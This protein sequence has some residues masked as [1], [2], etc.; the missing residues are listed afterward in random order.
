VA[1]RLSYVSAFYKNGQMLAEQYRIWSAYPDELKAQMEIVLVEDGDS[2]VTEHAEDVPRPDG[3]PDL[4]IYRL[5]PVQ[6][7]PS[8]PWRQHGARNRGAYEA[9]GEWLFLTD[10]DHVLPADSLR[11]LFALFDGAMPSDV[12]TFHRL[13]APHLTP[14]L[15]ERGE[16]KR[17]CNSF[18]MRRDHYWLVGGYDEDAVGYGTDSY[19]RRRLWDKSTER[20]LAGVPIIRYPRDVIPDASTHAPGVDPRELRNRGRRSSETRQRIEHKF[21]TRQPV[22]VLSLAWERVL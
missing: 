9:V 6:G 7:Q 13:D 17:H 4:R 15:N 8:P 21:L 1:K 5:L 18:A 11:A 10:M 20:H 19:F 22:K 16:L 14:T 12:F 3:L 2:S